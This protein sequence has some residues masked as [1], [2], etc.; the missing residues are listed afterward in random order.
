MITTPDV[1]QTIR[2]HGAATYPEECCG[3]LLGTVVPE[4]EL[5]HNVVH[6][7]HRIENAQEENRER[8]FLMGPADF[9]AADRAAR[10]QG[11][12]V[13]GTYHSHP[14]HPA[15]PSPTDLEHATFPGFTYIIVSVQQGVPA[16]LTTW[17]LAPDRSRFEPEDVA[18]TTSTE[19]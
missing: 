3:F 10:Q 6:A 19:T 2:D 8:R 18:L 14:D 7:I 15:R 11:L 12:D 9:L 13:V 1:L 5:M 16:D 17:S 4:G